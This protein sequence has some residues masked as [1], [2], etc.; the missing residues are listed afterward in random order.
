MSQAKRTPAS[1]MVESC[2]S[3][4]SESCQARREWQLPLERPIGTNTQLGAGS[5][6][7]CQPNAA[8]DAEVGDW[9]QPQT[10]TAGEEISEHAL[11]LPNPGREQRCLGR[12]VQFHLHLFGDRVD[13]REVLVGPLDAHSREG[14]LSDQAE[15]EALV[16][17][18]ADRLRL[19]VDDGQGSRAEPF[20]DARPPAEDQRGRPT[21]AGIED[22]AGR[23]VGGRDLRFGACYIV[24]CQRWRCGWLGREGV[25]EADG[26][27]IAAEGGIER[28]EPLAVRD[29]GGVQIA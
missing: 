9:K 24:R 28:A 29:V 27:S 18:P 25:V 12:H 2:F 6:R 17:N 8:V 13:A 3:A 20:D 11:L 26:S 7:V 4:K 16:S 1:S 23:R 19:C 22:Q 5:E 15:A 14:P 21:G 10:E